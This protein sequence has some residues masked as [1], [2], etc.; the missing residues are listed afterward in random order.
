MKNKQFIEKKIKTKPIQL[1]KLTPGSKSIEKQTKEIN[2][3]DFK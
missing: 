2:L 1:R 3:K